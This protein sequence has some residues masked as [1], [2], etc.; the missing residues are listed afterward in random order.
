MRI[1]IG[2]CGPTFL[3]LGSD[4]VP[5]SAMDASF[6][7]KLSAFD[8]KCGPAGRAA[9]P[10]AHVWT[11]H[12]WVMDVY[13]GM[14]SVFLDDIHGLAAHVARGTLGRRPSTPSDDSS[15]SSLASDLLTLMSFELQRRLFK[16]FE[17]TLD[18]PLRS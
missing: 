11:F 6:R 2:P 3:D 17:D 10:L 8:A 18:P 1:I 15:A 9:I 4:T 12:P 7:Q 5:D 13:G 16:F 14:H